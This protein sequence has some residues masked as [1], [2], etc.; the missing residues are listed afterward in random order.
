MLKLSRPA[1]FLSAFIFLF[2]VLVLCVTPLSALA[3]PQQAASTALPASSVAVMADTGHAE[4]AA[5]AHGEQAVNPADTSTA[6]L[7]AELPEPL[8]AGSAWPVSAITATLLA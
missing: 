6:D 2:A 4:P 8:A 1:Q 7:T 3:S 5:A